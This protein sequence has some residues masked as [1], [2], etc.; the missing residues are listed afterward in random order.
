VCEAFLHV[1]RRTK[2]VPESKGSAREGDPGIDEDGN[3]EK[4]SRDAA[5]YTRNKAGAPDRD[6]KNRFEPGR[7]F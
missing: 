4:V 3:S 2:G 5:E 1:R 6:K 7:G